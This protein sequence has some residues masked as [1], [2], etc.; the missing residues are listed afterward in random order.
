[1]TDP[2]ICFIIPYFGTWPFWLPFFLE[3][4]RAN[5]TVNW[6]I[7][8][9]CPIPKRC[10]P[11]VRIT[12]VTYED[13]CQLVSDT[14]RIDFRPENPYKL[15]DLKP[16]L[17]L[18]HREELA[19]FDFWAFGDIDV[20]YGDIRGYFTAARLSCKDLYATHERRI[21]GHFCL[22]RNTDLMRTAFM[23]IPNWQSRLT[24]QNHHALDE[25]AFSRLFI[26]HKNFPKALQRALNHLYPWRRRSEFVEAFSTPGA[27][28]PW[29][30]G[31]R[32][33]PECWYWRQGSL[34]ND[35]NGEREFPYLHFLVWKRS[36]WTER[37]AR[38][39]RPETVAYLPSWRIDA[40]GFAELTS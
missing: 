34:R 18:I 3:S 32:D 35:R 38:T 2:S 26:R 23:R 19:S 14:L 9:D 11:N 21:S 20:I 5:P 15:C 12:P 27:R 8:T 25:G 40:N 37:T 31:A 24:D 39:S 29:I 7:Y 17:G 1:M 16:A 30:G 6:L 13:Y 28:V 36:A 4:C 22:I 10:P 33:F